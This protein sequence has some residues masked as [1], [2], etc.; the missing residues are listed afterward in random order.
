MITV[1][2]MF[3]DLD[4]WIMI[5]IGDD[6]VKIPAHRPEYQH[7]VNKFKVTY[8]DPDTIAKLVLDELKDELKKPFFLQ[9]TF[10][11]LL[12]LRIRRKV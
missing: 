7:L 12:W 9:P 3:D 4:Y 8:S 5:G 6:I 11:K 2:K 10:W 1:Q